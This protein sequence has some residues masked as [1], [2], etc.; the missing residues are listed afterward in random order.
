M[1]ATMT[2]TK[3]PCFFFGANTIAHCAPS[4]FVDVQVY[5]INELCVFCF[6]FEF[7]CQIVHLILL[8]TIVEVMNEETMTRNE[9][10]NAKV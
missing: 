6:Y 3:S 8:I 2:N 7:F 5:L 1:T 9:R 10:A 4:S